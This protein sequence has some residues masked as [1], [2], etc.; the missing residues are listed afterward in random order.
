MALLLVL[1]GWIFD[2]TS[3]GC[4]VDIHFVRVV[5]IRHHLVS[6]QINENLPIIRLAQLDVRLETIECS[7]I[8][9]RDLLDFSK[10]LDSSIFSHFLILDGELEGVFV[11][12]FCI[13]FDDPFFIFHPVFKFHFGRL[14][15][16]SWLL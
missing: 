9:A 1:K 7:Q 15:I 8:I 16:S 2:E 3:G 13:D 10:K 5:F 12:L 4:N 14:L 11:V 6:N